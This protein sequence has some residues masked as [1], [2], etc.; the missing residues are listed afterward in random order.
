MKLLRALISAWIYFDH[1][2]LNLAAGAVI[3]WCLVAHEFWDRA[4]ER[5]FEDY[6]PHRST[7]RR[8]SS[9]PP[10]DYYV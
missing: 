6:W 4:E 9:I 8:M 7:G 5:F 2:W 3:G 10:T 1:A